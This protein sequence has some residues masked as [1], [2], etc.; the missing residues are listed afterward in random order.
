MTNRG[1]QT[2]IHSSNLDK[3]DQM[4][5]LSYFCFHGIVEDVSLVAV[6]TMSKLTRASKKCPSVH[7]VE[8]P[9]TGDPYLLQFED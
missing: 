4:V 9:L 8:V 5:W 6:V 7:N 1:F 3:T 2:I